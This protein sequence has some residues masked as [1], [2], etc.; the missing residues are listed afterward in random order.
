MHSDPFLFSLSRVAA[1]KEEP[2]VQIQAIHLMVAV[3]N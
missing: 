1:N 3:A 2:E